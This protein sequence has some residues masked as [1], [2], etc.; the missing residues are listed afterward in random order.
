MLC[1][2][3]LDI[4]LYNLSSVSP[5]IKEAC[6]WLRSLSFSH[7]TQRN[8]VILHELDSKEKHKKMKVAQPRKHLGESISLGLVLVVMIVAIVALMFMQSPIL[9]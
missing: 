9:P 6:L 7:L 4:F 8:I 1:A 5:S 3:K 2:G